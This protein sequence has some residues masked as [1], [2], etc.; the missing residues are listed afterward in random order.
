[1]Y[2]YINYIYI[3]NKY[4]KFELQLKKKKPEAEAEDMGI[5]YTKLVSKIHILDTLKES[6]TQSSLQ[7]CHSM[8]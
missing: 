6:M 5:V 7:R 2:I 4:P 3:Y 8:L 1:M